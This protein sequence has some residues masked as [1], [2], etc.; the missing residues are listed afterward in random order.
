MVLLL[1]DMIIWRFLVSLFHATFRRNWIQRVCNHSVFNPGHTLAE[2]AAEKAGIF[3]VKTTKPLL[4]LSFSFL[5]NLSSLL[6][7]GVPAFTVPQPNEAMRVLNEKATELK[8]KATQ[9]N[10]IIR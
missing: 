10:Q 1:L 8:V 2:I 5:L 7:S 6:Q 3:K 9:N 4:Y